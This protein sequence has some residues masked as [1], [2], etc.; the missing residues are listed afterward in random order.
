VVVAAAGEAFRVHNVPKRLQRSDAEEEIG[1]TEQTH[2]SHTAFV[3][4]INACDVPAE[5]KV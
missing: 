2:Y 1:L 4:P 3:E 5:G